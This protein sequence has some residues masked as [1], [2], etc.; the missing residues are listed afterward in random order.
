M[1]GGKL[2][3]QSGLRDWM[4]S[5]DWWYGMDTRYYIVHSQMRVEWAH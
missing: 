3:T 1:S 4:K 5:P 2:P